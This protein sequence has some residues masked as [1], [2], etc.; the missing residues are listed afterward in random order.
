MRLLAACSLGGGGHFQPLLPFLR[1]ARRRGDETIVI[2]PPALHDMVERAGFPFLAG[3]EPPESD[4]A[5]IRERLPIAP[6][7]EAAVLGN[8]DLFARLATM[9]MLPA[10]ERACT[11]WRPDFVLRDPCEYSSAVVAH[12]LGIRTAQVGISLADV[13]SG[14]ITIAAPALHEHRPGLV[15]ELRASP[16]LTPFP[17]SLDPSPFSGTVRFHEPTA[18]LDESPP[19]CWDQSDTPR[20]YMT[21]GTVL[22]HMSVAAGV[23]RAG[24]RAVADLGV[25]VLLT[26]GH[27]F[28]RSSLQPIPANVRVEAWVDQARALDQADLVVCHGGSGTVFGAL[29]A[30]VPSVMV[31]VFADQFVNASRIA[32]SGAGLVVDTGREAAGPSRRPIGEAGIPCITD[33]ITTVLTTPS[34]RQRA[35]RIAAE[36]RATPTVEEVLHAL[37]AGALP[38]GSSA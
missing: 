24:L 38:A 18:A 22:G 11:E 4:V 25:Q 21:F 15:E 12:G 14:S 5:S 13:E 10:M 27:H 31:P 28:D 16:Y 20:V 9:A 35:G 17:A 23:Y 7:S 37:E 33:G 36:M 6:P 3:G 19:D 8:R 34:Y 26:T 32:D 29:A 1:A 30:G 2:G